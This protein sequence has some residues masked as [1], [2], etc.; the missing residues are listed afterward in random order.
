MAHAIRAFAP[1][2]RHLFPRLAQFRELGY[3]V[4]RRG[5]FARNLREDWD[6][7]TIPSLESG[8]EVIVQH[9]LPVETLQFWKKRG[10]GYR[11]EVKPQK[12]E[13]WAIG[14]SE[15]GLG[16]FWWKFGDLEGDLR[17][18]G[19][20]N[21]EWFDGEQETGNYNNVEMVESE[22]ENGYGLTMDIENQAEV[23][24]E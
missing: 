15:G 4:H 24:F 9:R 20:K 6:F 10:D 17:D 3:R 1:I 16:T 11:D 23:T 22:G 21:D 5:S 19:F 8:K 7:I 14:P 18:R 2:S 12:G 13:S